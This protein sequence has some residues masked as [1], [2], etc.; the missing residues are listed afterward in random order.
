[1]NKNPISTAISTWTLT[2][3][4]QRLL[5]NNNVE[6]KFLCKSLCSYPYS[7]ASHVNITGDGGQVQSDVHV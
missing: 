4:R 5:L 2:G 1:M 7:Q 6:I 3:Q